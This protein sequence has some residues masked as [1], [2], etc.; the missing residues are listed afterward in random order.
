MS[1]A[2]NLV[3]AQYPVP[4][5][6]HHI[7][8]GLVIALTRACELRRAAVRAL[9]AGA[10]VNYVYV[11]PAAAAL[12]AEVNDATQPPR[13]DL[14]PGASGVAALHLAAQ[15]SRF[16]SV[17]TMMVS[18]HH[19]ATDLCLALTLTLR[20]TLNL[21]CLSNVRR[22]VGARWQKMLK[23]L[24]RPAL[25]WQRCQRDAFAVLKCAARSDGCRAT[26]R[27][28]RCRRWVWYRCWSCC[29]RAPHGRT[30]G[31]PRAARRCTTPSSTAALRCV[32]TSVSA[33]LGYDLCT[34]ARRGSACFEG[35][36]GCLL[37]CL[38]AVTRFRNR[39]CVANRP[40]SCSYAAARREP[41]RTAPAARRWT[42][43]WRARRCA[44]HIERRPRG[45]V[46]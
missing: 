20:L 36:C 39:W 9:A 29:S 37:R 14:P 45:F 4:T 26:A 38:R 32:A 6:V 41:S 15:V 22:T 24:G 42:L 12:V 46:S 11:T 28:C 27:H 35:C 44:E 16:R 25:D 10:D 19:T 23:V 5:S 33:S 31:T 7:A 34:S 1:P 17:P 43:S 2:G 40:R 8:R 3:Y 18:V 21:N 13:A 30:R